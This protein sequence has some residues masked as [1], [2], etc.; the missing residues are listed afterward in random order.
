V[1]R[2]DCL[3]R[4]STGTTVKVNVDVNAISDEQVEVG[5]KGST[6]QDEVRQVPKE[7]G[8]TWRRAKP[9][10]VRAIVRPSYGP[11]PT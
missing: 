2:N 1:Y 9:S 3:T 11:N 6:T 4:A 10:E 5:R 7:V 8:G